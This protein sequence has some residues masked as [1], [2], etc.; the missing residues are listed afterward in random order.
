MI[1]LPLDQVIL[2]MKH[3]YALYMKQENLK[4]KLTVK[5]FR[6]KHIFKFIWTAKYL[7]LKYKINKECTCT[8]VLSVLSCTPKVE[9]FLQWNWR[10]SEFEKTGYK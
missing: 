1:A 3:I 2:N 4:K 6:N 9:Q 5:T 8:Y 10:K 7:T